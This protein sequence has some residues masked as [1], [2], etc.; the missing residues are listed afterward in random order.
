MEK[1]LLLFLLTDCKRI[2]PLL[3]RKG[4][5][6]RGRVYWYY[7]YY[8]NQCGKPGMPVCRERVDPE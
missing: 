6:D 1:S 2:F 8:S 3:E 5:F 7:P 4:K